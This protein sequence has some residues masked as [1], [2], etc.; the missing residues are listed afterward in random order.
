[1]RIRPFTDQDLAA[2]YAIQV[3]CPL[4]G[5]W[6]QQDYLELAHEPGGSIFVAELDLSD[7]PLIA[8]FAAIQQILDEAELRNLVVH[9]SHRRN[10]IGR[11][12]LENLIRRLQ[13]SG[14]KELYLEVR[15]SNQ[16]ARAFYAAAGFK[17]QYTRPDYYRN[18]GEDALV[19]ALDITRPALTL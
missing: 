16:P 5:Q 18:P 15:P 17:L 7:Q 19:M 13:E 6:K 11:A 4:A 3:Q 14:A 2:I 8:G 1:M 9:S 10:G 12:L